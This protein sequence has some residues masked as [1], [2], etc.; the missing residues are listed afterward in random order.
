MNALLRVYL[1]VTL[2]YSGL[3]LSRQATADVVVPTQPR[4]YSAGHADLGV[5]YEGG[6]LGIRWFFGQDAVLDGKETQ[7]N[8][9]LD[10][11]E[12]F[13]RVG[14]DEFVRQEQTLGPTWSFTGLTPDVPGYLSVLPANIPK[15][16]EG[17]V[18]HLGFST[19]GLFAADWKNGQ[20]EWAMTA[21]KM[22]PGGEFS[23]WVTSSDVRFATSDGINDGD[24]FSFSVG[25]HDHFN[26]GFT[27]T[28]VYD[29]TLTVSGEH[30]DDGLQTG[31]A[32]FL[33]VVGDATA[34]PEAGTV[35]LLALGSLG[36]IVGGWHQRRRRSVTKGEAVA[37]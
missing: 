11:R 1:G 5:V 17:A 35:T 36:L 6:N 14:P 8:L 13:V 23:M 20:I 25:G 12:A 26:L 15:G 18:P 28:G 2:L 32:S 3:C 34:V 29:I 22:P 30:A 24:R 33:F 37:A 4:E 19:G 21:A 31:S 7:A 10:S 27:E 16:Q 9:E